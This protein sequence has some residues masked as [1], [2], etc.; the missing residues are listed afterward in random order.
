[1]AD[2]FQFTPRAL[3]GAG[4]L[5]IQAPRS[6]R[7]TVSSFIASKPAPTGVRGVLKRG[8]SGRKAACG[9]K[10]LPL[11]WHCRFAA[12]RKAPVYGLF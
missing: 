11:F 3:V 7:Q 12:G 8:G 9:G 10:P 2:I 5:A 4:L 6:A 1:V